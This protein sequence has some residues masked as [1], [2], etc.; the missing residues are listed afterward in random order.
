MTFLI[1]F[2]CIVGYIAI[3]LAMIR[4]SYRL[5]KDK[6]PNTYPHEC[7]NAT[8]QRYANWIGAFW[9]AGLVVLLGYFSHW[10]IHS[11]WRGKRVIE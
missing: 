6:I 11:A 3:A 1:V 9:P 5:L 7:A 8:T 4:A 10:L 2:A